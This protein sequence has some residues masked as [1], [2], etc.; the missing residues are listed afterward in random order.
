MD[1][2]LK[3]ASDLPLPDLLQILNRGFEEYPVPIHLS[4]SQFLDMT[5]KDSIDLTA[6]RVLF[7]DDKPQGVA[8]IARRGWTSR[9]AAMG[10]VIESRNQG[11]G[12][13]LMEKLIREA[14]ERGD[15]EMTLE[16]IEQNDP[17]IH[18]Y[19]KFGFQVIRRLIGLIRREAVEFEDAALQ[20]IDVRDAG[21]LISQYG[22]PNLPWQLS[23]ET[24]AQMTPPAR[25]FQHG[26]AFIVLSDPDANHVVVWSLLVKPEARGNRSGAILL[27]QVIA[28]RPGKTW[29]VPAIYPEEMGAVFEHACFERETLSQWQ[30]RLP[31]AAST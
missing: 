21:T 11:A 3:P 28:N 7:V 31:L 8:L 26:P 27:K 18:L 5:R 23:G 9:L 12:S 20:E 14:R 24:I 13:W 25:A 29:H 30:M 19:K 17:A 1:F 4:L 6:S 16:V 2:D 22:L 15:H 10:I